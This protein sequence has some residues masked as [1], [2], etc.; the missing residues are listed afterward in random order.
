M[1][2]RATLTVPAL[3]RPIITILVAL[4]EANTLANCLRTVDRYMPIS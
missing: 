3:A 4:S 2:G 1:I